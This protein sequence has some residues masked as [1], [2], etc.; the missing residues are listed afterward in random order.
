MASQKPM[1]TFVIDDALLRR[2]DDYRFEHRFESRAAAIKWLMEWALD[3]TPQPS[4][5]LGKG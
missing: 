5:R 3:Q 1:L 4:P 2:I